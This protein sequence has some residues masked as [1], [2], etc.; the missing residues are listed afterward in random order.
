MLPARKQLLFQSNSFFS[1]VFAGCLAAVIWVALYS[2]RATSSAFAVA[3]RV[4]V[5]V[6]PAA[7]ALPWAPAANLSVDGG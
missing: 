7:A 1:K 5:S 4:T 6:V 2:L 3:G